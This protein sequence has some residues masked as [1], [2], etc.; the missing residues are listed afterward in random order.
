MSLRGAF[1]D[2]FVISRDKDVSVDDIMYFP[3][4][5]HWDLRFSRNVHDWELE[6]LSSFMDLVYSIPLKGEGDDK[7]DW[8]H[9]P[10]KG[11]SVKEYYCCM[12]I[13]SFDPFPWKSIWKAKVL[14]RVAFFSWTAALGRL[15][16][17]DNL[18]KRNPILID[19][20]CMCKKSG[21]SV[22]HLLLHCPLAWKLW[23]MVLGLFGVH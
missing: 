4:G 1:P 9:N 2:L 12:S 8:R 18:R 10:N 13:V 11:F 5:I 17:I 7:L 16:T 15:F 19:W 21:E 3:N 6:S 20:C 23:S 14:P 22:D